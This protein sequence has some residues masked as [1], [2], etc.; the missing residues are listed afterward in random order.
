[1]V[2]PMCIYICFLHIV[3]FGASKDMIHVMHISMKTLQLWDLPFNADFAVK[4]VNERS[5]LLPNHELVL[6]HSI[7]SAAQAQVSGSSRLL[8]LVQFI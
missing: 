3:D 7:A 8:F 5:E 4:F 6:H 1:M 2:N